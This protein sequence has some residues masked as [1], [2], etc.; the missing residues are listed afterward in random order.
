MKRVAGAIAAAFCAFICPL[1]SVAAGPAQGR[2]GMVVTEQHYASQVGL[3]ILKAGGNAIDAAVA[4]G[5]ALAV[6]DPCCG[7]IG[8]GGFMLL[9]LANGKD[10]F[11]DFREK[12]PLAARPDMF[13]T[14]RGNVIAGASTKSYR[15]VGVAGTVAGLE[16]A[17]THFGT[18]SRARLMEPA[19]ALAEDGYRLDPGDVR[20]L[21]GSLE[22]IGASPR[23]RQIFTHDGK[24][25]VVGER[26]RQ[27]Q[28]A[29]TLRA[30]THEGA[31]AFYRGAIAQE[32]VDASRA[33]G[34]L[35]TLADFAEYRVDETPPVRC[36]YHGYDIA[37]APPP[38]SGGT[39]MC[40]I[41]NIVQGFPLAS[42]GWHSARTIHD[43]VEAERRAFADRN[44]Y[45]GDPSFVRNP[46]DKLLS[47]DYAAKIRSEIRP[48]RAVPS[49]RVSAGL[50]P[51]PEHQQTTHYSIVDRWGNAVAVTYTINDSFGS[52]LIAG[53]TG[54]LLNDEMDDFTVK[55]GAPNLYGLVQGAQNAVQGGKR[56]L[57]SMAPTIVTKNGALFLVAGSPG[58]SHIITI[59]L[60][61]LQ[62][63]IDY[64]MNVQAAVD[65]P[66]IHHQWLPDE[67][68]VEPGAVDSAER[69]S[70]QTMGYRLK[71][72]PPWG[73]AQAILIDP[74]TDALFGGSDH[75]RASGAALGY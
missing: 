21:R 54:F 30:I 41:L 37:S 27:P 53:D 49:A 48:D 75:R 42:Y 55:A 10:T 19:I 51:L 13:L 58:G 34:G 71:E 18:L 38:S 32:I 43:V 11:I 8:G 40:E 52:D 45:L 62:N 36:R 14:A 33:H 23:A 65:A 68:Q 15:S 6:V 59:T 7:N 9:R 72:Y 74:K 12:A 67:I 61:V 73:S 60:G 22:E 29:R 16:Y 26:L 5:Y 39:T 47:L 35:L 24:P 64:G 50:G 1:A 2:N 46:V 69:A 56:P 44:A 3:D 31:Q 25:Y 63:V 70:L 4:V 28:L 20:V 57:S 17:R 66:R